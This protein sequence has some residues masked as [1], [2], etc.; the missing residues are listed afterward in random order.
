MD[1]KWHL[2]LEW[3]SKSKK[4][5]VKTLKEELKSVFLD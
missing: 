3:F 5:K 1:E 4:L 2:L